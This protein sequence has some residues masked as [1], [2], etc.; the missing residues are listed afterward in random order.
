MRLSAWILVGFATLTAAVI[1]AF[2]GLTAYNL[3]VRPSATPA[4]VPLK[5]DVPL[6]TWLDPS[7]GSAAPKTT[8]IEYASYSCQYCQGVETDLKKLLANHSD[9]RLVWKDL[10]DP[11]VL[12]SDVAAE[13]AQCAK[14]QGKFW[15]F[16]DQLFA[17]PSATTSVQLSVIAQNLGLD[18]T[19]FNNCLEN[20]DMQPFVEHTVSEAAALGIDGEPY[21]FIN[22]KRQSGALSY[23]QFEAEISH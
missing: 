8:I 4:P 23:D 20:N 2:L 22:G 19:A 14:S 18:T 9:V 13:A 12:G 10:P 5:Q 17:D 16:H 21:F 15:E 3:G 6:V 1:L 7:R 11:N